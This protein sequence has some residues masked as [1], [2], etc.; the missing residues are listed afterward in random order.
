MKCDIVKKFLLTDYLDGQLSSES[1]QEISEHIDGC[2][3]CR[4]AEEDIR[5][6]LVAPLEGLPQNKAPEGL[7]AKIEDSIIFQSSEECTTRHIR[8]FKKVFYLWRTPVAFATALTLIFFVVVIF[9]LPDFKREIAVNEYL[10]DQIEYLAYLE[11]GTFI[12]AL[13]WIDYF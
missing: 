1:A 8:R 12:A 11:E 4:K 10:F 6:N 7:F 3:A 13:D 9:R 2:L 5:L